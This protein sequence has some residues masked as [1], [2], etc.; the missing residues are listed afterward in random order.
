MNI[1]KQFIFNFLEGGLIIGSL[2][3]IIDLLRLY[4]PLLIPYFGFLS[5]SF[6]FMQLFQYYYIK[7]TIHSYTE[8]FLKHS[9][10]GYFFLFVF[11]ILLYFTY[12][13]SNNK[14]NII[15]LFAILNI[16]LWIIYYFI[17]HH[18]V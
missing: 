7:K 16:L 17:Y 1:F 8:P 10:Y 5:A 9:I 18:Y 15:L 3:F 4:N 14:L 2:F 6:F 13:N 11:S 12:I